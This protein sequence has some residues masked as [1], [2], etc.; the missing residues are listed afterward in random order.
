MLD[1]FVKV[2]KSWPSRNFISSFDSLSKLD[3]FELGYFATS[4]VAF[5]CI[6][7]KINPGEAHKDNVAILYNSATK[8]WISLLNTD[9]GIKIDL[10]QESDANI[11]ANITTL[12]TN[13]EK[14]K[15]Q[16]VSRPPEVKDQ[17]T[18]CILVERK[19]DEAINYSLAKEQARKV[20]FAIGECRERAALIPIFQQS[21]GADLVQLALHKWMD[22]A[23]RL[24]QDST[25]PEDK[26]MPLVKNFLQI[27]KWLKDLVMNQLAGIS[28]AR[29][30]IKVE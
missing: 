19:V 13:L 16:F 14:Y 9:A 1:Q 7:I 27:K 29:Q 11:D 20:Y 30:E 25:F 26:I 17:I 10:F 3:V 24:P 8:Q 21:N 28:T 23:L 12:K 15:T 2:Q 5:R 4:D 18:K 6:S 22:L